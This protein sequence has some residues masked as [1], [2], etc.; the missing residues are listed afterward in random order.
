MRFRRNKPQNLLEQSQIV[1]NLT[2][3]LSQETL[4]QLLPFIDNPK[5]EIEKLEDEKAQNM[6]DFGTYQNFAKAFQAEDTIDKSRNVEA[7]EGVDTS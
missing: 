7:P 3:L 2:S 5:E 1:G 4:L 6:D